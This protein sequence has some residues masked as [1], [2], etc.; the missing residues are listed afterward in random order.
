MYVARFIL[1]LQTPL[2]CGGGEDVTQDQP[3]SRDAFGF[4]RI[5]GS[6]VAGILRGWMRDQTDIRGVESRLFGKQEGVNC[7]ASLIWCE[8][9]RLLDF[10]EVPVVEK[11]MGGQEVA[12]PQGPYIRDHVRLGLGTEVAEEGGKF[13][14]EIVPPGA[15]FALELRLDAWEKA[16]T[17]EEREVFCRLCAA[18]ASGHIRLGG[19]RASGYGRV[20]SLYAACRHF[21]L[22]TEEGM[23]AWLNLAPAP[24]FANGD[25]REVALPDAAPPQW[26]GEGLSADLELPLTCDAPLIVGGVNVRD[27]ADII[28][29]MTPCLDY[30]QK[31]VEPRYTLPGSSLRGVLRH[32]VYR[33]AEA[34]DM[35]AA[36]C[37]NGLFGHASGAEGAAGKVCV[38]DVLLTAG[39]PA[40]LQ[41]VAI[42]RFTGGALSGALFDECPLWQDGLEVPLRLEVREL[43]DTEARLLLHALLDLAEGALP[44]GN[45]VNRGNGVLRLRGMEQGWRKA[46]ENVRCDAMRQGERLDRHDASMCRRWLEDIEGDRP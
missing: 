11:V 29:L 31:R 39:T 6:S 33:V 40:H 24:R 5:P 37:V 8:D 43:T 26:R 20:R 7:L 27:E 41:H 42:D 36:V 23:I 4:W 34:L 28:C 10:D 16:A 1:E 18:L 30:A 15:R 45:G 9:A 3:V 44:V 13:D 38:E 17:S 21:D 14:E 32:R 46:L 35:D 22:D 12:I 25:G 19:K 2:H